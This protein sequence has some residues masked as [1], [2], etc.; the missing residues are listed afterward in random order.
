[1]NAHIVQTLLS[2]V[3]DLVAICVLLLREAAVAPNR[4][5]LVA[6]GTFGTATPC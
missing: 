1:M 3:E 5:R 6:S 4:A 2:V